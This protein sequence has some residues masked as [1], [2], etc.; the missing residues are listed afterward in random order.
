MH[1]RT[2][3]TSFVQEDNG[4]TICFAEYTSKPHLFDARLKATG[5]QPNQFT[6]VNVVIDNQSLYTKGQVRDDKLARKIC[7][8]IGQPSHA[9]FLKMIRNNLL[10]KWPITLN[11]A[12]NALQIYGPDLAAVM[13]TT[14]H[15]T[16][17]IVH[18]DLIKKLQREIIVSHS[19]V[20]IC[21]YIFFVDGL[22]FWAQYWEVFLFWAQQYREVC[23]L[24]LLNTYHVDSRHIMKQVLPCI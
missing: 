4:Q 16:S 2:D 5:T 22:A 11:N 21:M 24:L 19:K 17:Q 3:A 12:N 20:T 23:D 13:G 1:S 8:M 9:T 10:L 6:Y 18:Y 15:Q 14:F 7:I